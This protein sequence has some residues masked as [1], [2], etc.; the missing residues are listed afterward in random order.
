MTHEQINFI[1][2][3]VECCNKYS[4]YGILPSLTIAQAIKES[5]WGKSKLGA[6]YFNFF[7]MKW[8]K[9]CNCEYVELPTKEWNGSCYVD[10]IAKFRKYNSFEDGIRGYYDFLTSYKRYKNLVGVKDSYTACLLI[11]QDGW[12]TSP[13]YGVSLYND[14]VVRYNLIQY[15][16]NDYKINKYVSG[17]IYVTAVNLYLRTAPNGEKIKHAS[18]CDGY[19]A[20]AK[21]DDFGCA[22]LLKG[23]RVI[24]KSTKTVDNQIWFEVSCGWLCAVNCDKEYII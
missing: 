13:T 16:G 14:Y 19:R 24:C 18:L 15:D 20:N 6:N 23:T 17:E 4:Y 7:G 1:S 8:S 10:V 3:V 11:Q 2:K 5:N 9:D 12:A 21:F 22:I